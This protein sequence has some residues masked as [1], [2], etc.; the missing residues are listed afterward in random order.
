[1]L[2]PTQP[3]SDEKTFAMRVCGWILV[4]VAIY[5]GIFVILVFDKLLLGKRRLIGHFPESGLR[6][7]STIYM[8]LGWLLERL[9]G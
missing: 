6:I 3:D 5:V 7:L 8:P 9:L 2:G 4:S 1:M